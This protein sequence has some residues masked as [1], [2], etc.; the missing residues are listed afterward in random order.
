MGAPGAMTSPSVCTKSAPPRRSWPSTPRGLATR[1]RLIEAALQE[2]AERGY[3]GARVEAITRLAGLSYGT[4]YRYF[5]NK[6]DLIRALADQVYGEIFTQATRESSS[7]RPVPERV[8]SDYLL[9]LR[10]FVRNRDVLRVLNDAVGADPAVAAEVAVF[11]QRDV[12][13]YAE[14]IATTPGYEPVGDSQTISLLVNAMGD[15]VARRWLRSPRCTGNADRDDPELR[16]LACIF[17]IMCTA[18]LSPSS[19]GIDRAAI[20]A[21]MERITPDGES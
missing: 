12:D 11:E 4:F 5:T 8:F 17:T 7:P 20:A 13:R 15:E 1:R 9:S 16:R 6:A 21:I 3:V 14:I 19:L 18:V 10:A 2:F